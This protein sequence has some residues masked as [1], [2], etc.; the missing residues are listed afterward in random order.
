MPL[1]R[2]TCVEARYGVPAFQLRQIAAICPSPMLIWSPTRS[3]SATTPD[4]LIALHFDPDVAAVA[5]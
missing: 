3:G 1:T 5:A 2:C 4:H